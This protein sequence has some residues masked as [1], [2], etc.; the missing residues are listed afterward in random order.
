M[1]DLKID[2][3]DFQETPIAPVVIEPIKKAED[4][5]TKAQNLLNKKV[6]EGFPKGTLVQYGQSTY[7]VIGHGFPWNRPAGVMLKNVKTHGEIDIDV[8]MDSDLKKL[9]IL[10][11]PE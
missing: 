3:E 6:K 7:E 11:Y 4:M 9:T 1:P 5:L 2:S 8:T 10:E